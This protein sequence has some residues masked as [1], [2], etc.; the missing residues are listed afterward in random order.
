MQIVTVRWIILHFIPLDFWLCVR[1]TWT[2]RVKCYRKTYFL[3]VLLF[4]S[5]KSSTSQ[6]ISP[7]KYNEN[8][9][10]IML[11]KTSNLKYK[12]VIF[13][14]TPLSLPLYS[15]SLCHQC[16]RTTHSTLTLQFSLFVFIAFSLK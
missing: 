12:K 11:F 7:K 5:H 10:R 8:S 3:M 14:R 1:P 13:V 9:R 16:H 6:T 15:P 4:A 2:K